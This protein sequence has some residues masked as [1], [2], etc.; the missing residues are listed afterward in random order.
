M[1]QSFLHAADLHIGTPLASLGRR[2]RLD[3]VALA[4]LTETMQSA[5]DRLVDLAI[6]EQVAFVVLAGDVYDNAEAQD[7]QQGRFHAGLERLHDAGIPTFIALGNHDPA[8]QR[9]RAR[10]PLPPSVHVFAPDEPEER[11]VETDGPVVHVAG[12]SYGR[13]AVDDNLAA[14]FRRFDRQPGTLRVGVLHTSLEGSAEHASYAPCSVAD[15]DAAPVDYWALGHIHLRQVARLSGVGRWYAYPGN[16]QG[17]SFKPSECHPKGALLVPFDEYGIGE[18]TF[19]ALDT[20]RFT[21]LSVDVS[22]ADEVD[23]VHESVHD[24]IVGAASAAEGRRLVARVELTG[25]SAHHAEFARQ[26]D[27]GRFLERFDDSFGDALGAVLLV[28]V[29]SSVAPPLDTSVLRQGDD[30]L[31]A[32]LRRLDSL[33][34]SDLLAGLDGLVHPRFDVD[35]DRSPEQV[36][37]FRTMVESALVQELAP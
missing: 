23:A 37:G 15:L 36:G 21:D 25:R 31:S 26:V 11:L 10:R 28:G 16:L 34:D 18:P 30:L 27:A 8:E 3:D 13:T 1:G 9:V 35:L 7:A 17:R 32:A 19:R 22:D 33:S 20:V 12:V 6:D 2:A 29:R 4:E 14:R 24:A 5:Y